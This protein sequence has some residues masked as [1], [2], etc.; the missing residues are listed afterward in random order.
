MTRPVLPPVGDGWA[1]D[2]VH[3]AP[4]EVFDAQPSRV[5]PS[6]GKRNAG[7]LPSEV[8]PAEV[9]NDIVADHGAWL[10]FLSEITAPHDIAIGGGFFQ[11]EDGS[12]LEIV[13]T[14]TLVG[15][16]SGLAILA[17]TGTTGLAT[18]DLQG[19]LKVPSQHAITGIRVTGRYARDASITVWLVQRTPLGSATRTTLLTFAGGASDIAQAL[20]ESGSFT[21]PAWDL[22]GP[23]EIEIELDGSADAAG[24]IAIFDVIV[25]VAPA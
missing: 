22:S 25:T 13:R 17:P 18:A 21:D 6:E 4:G 23:C 3:D 12:D 5:R 7:M 14:S 19:R 16:A 10:A 15:G 9:F 1:S 20:D 2:A 8:L 24:F 11:R